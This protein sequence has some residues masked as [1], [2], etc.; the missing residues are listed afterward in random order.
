MKLAL[1]GR[2]WETAQGYTSTFAE[3][4][5]IAADL[6]YEGIEM[7]YPL[8]PERTAWDETR[9]QLEQADITLVFAP[10]GIPRDEAGYQDVERVLDALK[11]MGGSYLK[12]IPTAEGDEEGMR[13]TA[14]LGAERGI[15]VLSQLHA[16]TLTDTVERTER[17]LRE[18]N[19]P[20][21]GLIFDACH[22]P[23]V[24]ELPIETAVQRLRPWINLANVQSYKLASDDHTLQRSKIGNDEWVLALPGD[25]A[26]TDLAESIRALRAAGYD[27]W[28][29]VMPAV[30]PTW[31]PIEV[32][33]AYRDFLQPLM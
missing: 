8:V 24:E 12:V 3:Q 28:V 14:D 10:A 20:N 5:G 29:T 33:K 16:N 1:S 17:F 21:L 30:D 9:R 18:V 13:R 32:A 15:K 25:P 6:G 23:F 31:D 19:H 26:G 4:I 27:G 22:I 11:T 7:R 2:L